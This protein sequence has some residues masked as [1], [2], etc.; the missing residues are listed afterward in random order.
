M[1]TNDEL[2]AEQG[3]ITLTSNEGDIAVGAE[4][5]AQ[6]D[7]TLSA[8]AGSVAVDGAVNST[9]GSVGVTADEAIT[10]TA[11]VT[12]YSEVTLLSKEGIM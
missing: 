8:E 3:A 12:A 11:E 10:T 1:T 5:T 4:A 7:V 6:D 2:S 9:A